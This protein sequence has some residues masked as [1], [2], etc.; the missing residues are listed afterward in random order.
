[1]CRV[2][3]VGFEPTIS[4][5]QSRRLPAWPRARTLLPSADER[6]RTSTP[7]RAI[8]PK[9]IASANSA[10]SGFPCGRLS[11]V[12]C[13]GRPRQPVRLSS[14]GLAPPSESWEG[15][16]TPDSVFGAALRRPE[17]HHLSR[18]CVRRFVTCRVLPGFVRTAATRF[19]T[20]FA[21]NA[22]PTRLAL[23][24]TL[25]QPAP[26]PRPLVGSYPTVSPLAGPAA[27]R[28]PRGGSAFCCGCSHMAVAG[29][30]PPLT[31]SWGNV[32]AM[33]RCRHRG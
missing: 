5:L 23:R 19:Y 32:P 28:R 13:T 21:D 7:F 30:A 1:M 2:D 29:R 20:I 31:V 18:T 16:C 6:T 24:C 26:F 15:R 10:T 3:P 8:D 33:L 25:A 12:I 27:L 11:S 9:S 22:K 14:T 4:C 17:G